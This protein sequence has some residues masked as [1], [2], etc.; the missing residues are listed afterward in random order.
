MAGPQ[1]GLESV[2]YKSQILCQWKK[3]PPS[4]VSFVREVFLHQTQTWKP[5]AKMGSLLTFPPRNSSWRM[6]VIS[7]QFPLGN[8]VH[9]FMY[10]TIR[11]TWQ[12]TMKIWSIKYLACFL[13]TYWTAQASSEGFRIHVSW[14]CPLK[15]LTCLR[16]SFSVRTLIA[17]VLWALLT[18][19]GAGKALESHI[20]QQI[21]ALDSTGV[22][23]FLGLWRCSG[24]DEK[25]GHQGLLKLTCWENCVLCQAIWNGR[26]YYAQFGC[27][28]IRKIDQVFSSCVTRSKE[29]FSLWQFDGFK[30]NAFMHLKERCYGSEKSSSTE[31]L[32]DLCLTWET[33]ES[34]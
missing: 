12:A 31:L 7:S 25:S 26:L 27:Y 4:S 14:A 9:A 29:R 22:Y 21:G 8:R 11:S 19:N 10:C 3:F 16:H 32:E 5:C 1:I 20:V 15:P 2:D 17:I 28:V 30:W 23:T 33:L 34:V 24:D 18:R 6:L 13:A